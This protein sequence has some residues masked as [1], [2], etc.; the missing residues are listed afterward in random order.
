MYLR[1]NGHW[2]KCHRTGCP[3]TNCGLSVNLHAVKYLAIGR[4]VYLIPDC[5]MIEYRKQST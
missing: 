3:G 2:M 1:K 4:I 5:R